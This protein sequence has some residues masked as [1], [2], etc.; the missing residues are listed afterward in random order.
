MD[1]EP[2]P[3]ELRDYFTTEAYGLPKAGGWLD[4]PAKR[5]RGITAAGNIYRPFAS[6]KRSQDKIAWSR[7]NPE[8]F[9]LVSAYIAKRNGWLISN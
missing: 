8:G 7:Q 5:M 6:Y 1:G 9:D 2:A 3:R 4:Q